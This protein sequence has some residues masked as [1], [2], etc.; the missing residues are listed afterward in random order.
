MA[1]NAYRMMGLGIGGGL[2]TANAQSETLSKP[3][4]YSKP[5]FEIE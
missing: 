1:F 2:L 4:I 5:I 3:H